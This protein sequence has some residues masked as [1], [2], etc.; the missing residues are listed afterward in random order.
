MLLAERAD[1]LH[2]LTTE[3]HSR[4]PFVLKGIHYY[5]GSPRNMDHL[6][7]CG[8]LEARAVVICHHPTPSTVFVVGDDDPGGQ[9]VPRKLNADRHTIIVSL[10]LHFLLDSQIQPLPRRHVQYSECYGGLDNFLEGD[11]YCPFTFTVAGIFWMIARYS[12]LQ[13]DVHLH[14]LTEVRHES[15]EA[16]L[17]R[18]ICTISSVPTAESNSRHLSNRTNKSKSSRNRFDLLSA[19][20]LMTAPVFVSLLV[21]SILNPN[22]VTLWETVLAGRVLSSPNRS[23]QAG[24]GIHPKAKCADE[25]IN[26]I[27]L[28]HLNDRFH[29]KSLNDVTWGSNNSELVQDISTGGIPMKTNEVIPEL[30]NLRETIKINEQP[31]FSSDLPILGRIACPSFYDGLTFGVFFEDLLEHSGAISIGVHHFTVVNTGGN[32]PATTR[33][34]DELSQRESH[35]GIGLFPSTSTQREILGKS[36]HNVNASVVLDSDSDSDSDFEQEEINIFNEDTSSEVSND[37][38]AEDAIWRSDTSVVMETMASMPHV[39]VAPSSGFV[40]SRH[41]FIFILRG[42]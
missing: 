13:V 23:V 8:V 32:P 16:Y 19:G 26:T 20:G 27:Q 15:N 25:N 33:Q 9:T 42:S 18:S 22:I 10:N 40:L 30:S 29:P 3:A 14:L 24:Q 36:G 17:R 39:F 1:E 12:I 35:V 6:R 31:E 2:K 11:N 4:Y 28:S 37:F 5:E 21:Q 34:H 38:D 7:L 41:D